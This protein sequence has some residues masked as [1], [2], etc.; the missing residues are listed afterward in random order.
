MPLDFIPYHLVPYHRLE[1]LQKNDAHHESM[2]TARGIGKFSE[3]IESDIFIP[4]GVPQVGSMRQR[5]HHAIKLVGR[6]HFDDPHLF[7]KHFEFN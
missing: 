5:G 1:M 6:A 3:R 2:F 7:D 4:M